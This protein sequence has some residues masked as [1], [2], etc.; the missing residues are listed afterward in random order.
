MTRWSHAQEVQIDFHVTQVE[1]RQSRSLTCA[2]GLKVVAQDYT[3]DGGSGSAA[4][5]GPSTLM[6]QL[7]QTASLTLGL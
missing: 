7:G 1:T 5:E 2:G 3:S 4:G 6:Q